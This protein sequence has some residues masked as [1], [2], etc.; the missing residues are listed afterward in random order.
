M[1][2]TTH[3]HLVPRWRMRGGIPPL[4]NTPAWRGAQVKH[5]DIFT[6]TFKCKIYITRILSLMFPVFDHYLKL[7]TSSSSSSSSSYASPFIKWHCSSRNWW[8][9]TTNTK[10]DSQIW[11]WPSY[12]NLPTSKSVSKIR[13]NSPISSVFQVDV[14]QKVSPPKFCMHYLSPPPS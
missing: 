14:F 7:N 10:A 2:L 4:P 13:H 5:W 12:I 6:F 11:S 3:H 1:K 9:I 8:F